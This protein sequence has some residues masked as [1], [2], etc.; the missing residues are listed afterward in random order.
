[1]IQPITNGHIAY[2]FMWYVNQPC[3]GY[4]GIDI[5][6]QLF[7]YRRVYPQMGYGRLHF[8]EIFIGNMR[9]HRGISTFSP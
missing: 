8:M 5:N 2:V 9:I 1:M 4:N 7:G 3:W 6:H